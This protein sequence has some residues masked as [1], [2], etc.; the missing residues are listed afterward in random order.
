ML[1]LLQIYYYRIFYSSRDRLHAQP[2]NE[3][4]ALLSDPESIKPPIE[5]KRVSRKQIIVEYILLWCIVFAFGIG[6][7]F[8]NHQSSEPEG[9]KGP[10][11]VFEWKSQTLGWASALMYLGSRIPQIRKLQHHP[12]LRCRSFYI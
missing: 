12:C 8:F 4:N 5:S 10:S 7:F 6:A 1:L 9:S 11:D 3:Q 2:N